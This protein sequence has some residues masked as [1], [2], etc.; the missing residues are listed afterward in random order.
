MSRTLC[1]A[2]L[3]AT[4][5]LASLDA[6]ASAAQT[7]AA[8]QKP[9]LPKS[10]VPILGRPTKPEDPA[11][12]LDF[13]GYF[14]G[15]WTFTWDFPE[16]GLGPA[17]ELTG[18]TVFKAIDDKFFEALTE[19]T[20]PDGPVT[21]REVIGY[22]K[23]SRTLSRMV[24]DSRGFSYLQVGTVGGDLGGQFT[25]YFDSAPFVHNGHTMRVKSMVKL[26]S[27]FNYRVQTTISEDGGPF[28]NYGHPWWKKDVPGATNKP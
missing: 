15:K 17:G 9:E 5:T 28:E 6:R 16:T 4:S 25:I 2:A 8:P 3:V 14:T 21:I 22:L 24:T 11:P 7:Q 1:V 20:S 26:L 19:A 12:I 27:P 18:T 13:G 10:Q 23:D